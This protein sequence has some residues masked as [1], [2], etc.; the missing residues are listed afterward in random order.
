MGALAAAL[1]DRST[2]EPFVLAHATLIA[3]G[4]HGMLVAGP[5]GTGKSTLGGRA[6]R[7]VLG[8]NAV[9][10][11]QEQERL[12]ALPLPLTGRGDASVSPRVVQVAGAWMLGEQLPPRS[13]AGRVGR[14]LGVL[15]TA[16]GAPALLE[17]AIWL[18]R[19]VRV[20]W[21]STQNLVQLRLGVEGETSP[22]HEA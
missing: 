2:R 12:M 16:Q 1:V 20:R 13:M 5:S 10:L 19:Q 11:W 8:S 22:P 4:N 7:H 18:A 6:G 14:W 21:K 17:Q 15:A 3:V 9:L